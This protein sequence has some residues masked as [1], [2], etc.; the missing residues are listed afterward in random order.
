MGNAATLGAV[1]RKGGAKPDELKKEVTLAKVTKVTLNLREK[2]NVCFA[3]FFHSL[4]CR[5]NS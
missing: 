2:D 5:V 1:L 4:G 3:F